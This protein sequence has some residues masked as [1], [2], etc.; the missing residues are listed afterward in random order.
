MYGGKSQFA[1]QSEAEAR[2]QYN[3]TMRALNR[4]KRQQR[5]GSLGIAVIAALAGWLGG[6][7]A[8]RRNTDRTED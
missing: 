8:Q 6:T 5:P 1:R 7:F 2:R 3:T 4:G